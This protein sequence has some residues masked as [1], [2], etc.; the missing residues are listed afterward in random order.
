MLCLIAK[1]ICVMTYIK[2][3]GHERY[4]EGHSVLGQRNVA[5]RGG[6]EMRERAFHHKKKVLFL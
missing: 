5:S 1:Q 2:S 6:E 3:G 4:W